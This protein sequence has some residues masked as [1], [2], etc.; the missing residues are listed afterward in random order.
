[1]LDYQPGIRTYTDKARNQ[2]SVHTASGKC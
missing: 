2:D 1:M